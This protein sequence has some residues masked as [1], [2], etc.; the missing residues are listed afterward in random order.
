MS[1]A[2]NW[3]PRDL[4]EAIRHGDLWAIAEAGHM[5]YDDADY[6]ADYYDKYERYHGI[7]PVQDNDDKYMRLV[8]RAS[9]RE[10]NRAIGAGNIA[11]IAY[12]AGHRR[13]DNTFWNVTHFVESQWAARIDGSG[14]QKSL[15]NG[16]EGSGKT[17]YM[18][19]EGFEIAP[20]VIHRETDKKVLGLS[21]VEV[22]IETTNLDK[23]EQVT[24]TSRLDEILEEYETKSDWEIILALD[25][26]DQLF[27]GFGKSQNRASELGNRI[28]LMRHYGAHILMTSQR[29]VAPEI[30]NRFK[31]RH[32]PDDRKPWKMVFAKRTTEEGKPEDIIFRTNNVPETN[33]DYGSKGMWVHDVDDDLLEADETPE[34][35]E[36]VRIRCQEMTARGNQCKEM[37]S[38]PSGFC[39]KYHEYRQ[40]EWESDDDR[41]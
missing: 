29:Q 28:K 2:E 14:V 25:E 22:D 37:T 3:S 4:M 6:V 12:A 16:D 24:R 40:V 39:S 19:L 8:R 5:E 34:E 38:H 9:T 18:M 17:D 33:V 30:R 21:N 32:K 26:G 23:F 31:I 7:D 15:I 1:D 27:G 20:R 11:R 36:V 41:V 10:F 13:S 35:E